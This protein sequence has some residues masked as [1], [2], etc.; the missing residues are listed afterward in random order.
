[1]GGAFVA[2]ADDASATYWNPGGLALGQMFS[3]T[4]DRKVADQKA[5]TLDDPS[6][7]DTGS[8]IA[9]GMPSVKVLLS[10]TDMIAFLGVIVGGIVISM[11]L[12]IFDLITKLSGG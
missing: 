12:P 6:R 8:L 9:L 7:H 3:A 10:A 5:G 4:V 2:V 1:M 11:Y